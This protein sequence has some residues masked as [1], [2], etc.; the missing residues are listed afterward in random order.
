MVTT[1][2]LREGNI[3]ATFHGFQDTAIVIAVEEVPDDGLDAPVR[4]DS[5]SHWQVCL[6][7]CFQFRLRVVPELHCPVVCHRLEKLANE[8]TYKR[9]NETLQ[10]LGG[11]VATLGESSRIVDVLFGKT[12]PMINE[13]VPQWTPINK[14]VT[15]AQHLSFCM[16]CLLLPSSDFAWPLSHR[17]PLS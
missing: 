3:C 2:N 17:S 14:G 11:G 16:S 13:K 7:Q 6:P 8:V 1:L 5:S 9:Y 4:C 15:E 12:E 10:C